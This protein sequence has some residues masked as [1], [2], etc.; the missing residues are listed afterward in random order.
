MS[1]K[2][3]NR[4]RISKIPAIITDYLIILKP[5]IAFYSVYYMGLTLSERQKAGIK[6]IVLL[7]VLIIL[8][9]VIVDYELFVWTIPSH[10]SRF[11][12]IMVV[13]AFSYYYCSKR[14]RLS[15]IYTILILSISLLSFRSKA[16]G[17]F[18]LAFVFLFF[19][20]VKKFK[21]NIISLMGIIV[22]LM[23]VIYVSWGKISFYFVEG[24][25]SDDIENFMA[26]PALYAGAAKIIQD[27]PLMGPGL[28]TYASYASDKYYSPLYSKYN[29]DK[30]HGL[31][32]GGAFISDTFFPSLAQ[33]GLIGIFL[34]FFFFYRR[35]IEV[36]NKKELTGDVIWFKMSLLFFVFFLIESTSDSTFVQ[37]RGMVMMMLLAMYINENRYP[38][39]K[40]HK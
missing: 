7:I 27:Y 16:Y 2:K 37:N 19:F 21:M 39:I 28:G 10:A 22:C 13:L 24:T 20:N 33:Y 38:K 3:K 35:Y 18:V 5:F 8:L 12:T 34:F 1:P 17:F 23:L 31:S 26:R 9:G 11:A 40:Y 25:Q 36:K 32:E 30:V 15:L 14:N 29:L 4:F 6:T